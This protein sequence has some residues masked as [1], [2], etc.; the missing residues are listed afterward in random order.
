MTTQHTDH[1]QAVSLED[2]R[3]VR[4]MVVMAS[5]APWPDVDDIA[6]EVLCALAFRR[7][8][9][10]VPAGMTPAQARTAFL[11]GVVRRQVARHAQRHV[12]FEVGLVLGAEVLAQ[13][14][15]PSPE[16]LHI[17]LAASERLSRA[18]EQ[19][20]QARPELHEVLVLVAEEQSIS[21]IA[22]RLGVPAGTVSSRW[23]RAREAVRA[24]VRRDVAD[25]ATAGRTAFVESIGAQAA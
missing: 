5:H 1:P 21:R 8:P 14:P 7:H 22:A 4:R 10:D 15:A 17:A 16:D 20:H 24:F 3:A 9:I 6:Q 23:L 25:E 12:R 2:V 13:P 19:L 18:M 11:W